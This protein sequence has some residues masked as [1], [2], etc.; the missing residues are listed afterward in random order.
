[1][2][3]GLSKMAEQD[4]CSCYIN[5]MAIVADI[6]SDEIEGCS[7]PKSKDQLLK[8]ASRFMSIAEDVK[9]RTVLSLKTLVKTGGIKQHEYRPLLQQ[10][11]EMV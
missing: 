2:R 3:A 9:Y 7:D 11:M 4:T 10:A 5:A 1:M 8:R 6:I